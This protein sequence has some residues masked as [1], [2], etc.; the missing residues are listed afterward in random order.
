M[1]RCAGFSCLYCLVSCHSATV[2]Q[3]CQNFCDRKG[4]LAGR[5]NCGGSEAIWFQST[6][7]SFASKPFSEWLMVFGL[8]TMND[9]VIT[10]YF[11]V[12]VFGLRVWARFSWATW[13]SLSG[14]LLECELSFTPV[15]VFPVADHLTELC[16]PDHLCTCTIR[17]TFRR[18]GFWIVWFRSNSAIKNVSCAKAALLWWNGSAP[19]RKGKQEAYCFNESLALP[20][21]VISHLLRLVSFPSW[22]SAHVVHVGQL[23]GSKAEAS[24]RHLFSRRVLFAIQARMYFQTWEGLSDKNFIERDESVPLAQFSVV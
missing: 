24:F 11:S 18:N 12:P 7:V 14:G 13:Q 22:P 15:Q 2:V 5:I 9:T 6:H 23:C 20:H 16:P 10:P 3:V 21:Q 1:S 19:K 4:R 8:R 17:Q